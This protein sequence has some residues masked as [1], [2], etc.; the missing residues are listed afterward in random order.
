MPRDVSKHQQ[1]AVTST[2][3]MVWKRG[4]VVK[5]MENIIGYGSE[6]TG[7]IQDE[8]VS[9]ST[10]DEGGRYTKDSVKHCGNRRIFERSAREVCGHCF[11]DSATVFHHEGEPKYGEHGTVSTKWECR[12]RGN[13]CNIFALRKMLDHAVSP[14][15]NFTECWQKCR[16]WTEERSI[17]RQTKTWMWMSGRRSVRR[18]EK[19][20]NTWD[21]TN[22]WSWSI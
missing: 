20:R 3:L 17:A 15:P 12:K 21:W 13:R 19:L 22:R 18:S 11:W 1:Q 2:R 14:L 4:L 7:Y 10:R 8:W 5:T 6:D 16:A 9:Q